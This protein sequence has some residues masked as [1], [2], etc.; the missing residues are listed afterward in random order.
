M[1]VYILFLYKFSRQD[2]ESEGAEHPRGG[3]NRHFVMAFKRLEALCKKE[4]EEVIV[5]LANDRNGFFTKIE[6]TLSGDYIVL[7]VRVLEKMCSS[8]FNSNKTMV[9]IKVAKESF[10]EQLKKFVLEVPLHNAID[11]NRNKYFWDNIDQFWR[12]LYVLCNTILE[13]IPT[14][15][16]EVLPKMVTAVQMTVINI[17]NLHHVNISDGIKENYET[18]Q[19]KIIITTEE[20]EKKAQVQERTRIVSNDEEMLPP[21]NFREMSVYPTSEEVIY[22]DR[23]FV[24]RNKIDGPYNDVEEYLDIQFR[25]LREDFVAPLRQGI[26]E[27]TKK[28][29]NPSGKKIHSVRVHRRVWFIGTANVRDV[30]GVKVGDYPLFYIISGGMNNVLE[31]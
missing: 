15:A 16:I 10:M 21:N 28:L 7:I 11:K 8:A 17:Q 13:L 29:A 19:E 12:D 30:I 27:Y 2:N 14:T 23:S 26:C 4:P 9:I 31:L 3:R 22:P 5:E 1:N 18:L 6:D 20:I 24:R 25:L